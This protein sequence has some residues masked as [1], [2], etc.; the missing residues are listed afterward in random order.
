MFARTIALVFI[1]SASAQKCTEAESKL[2]IDQYDFTKNM[3]TCAMKGMGSSK[4]ASNCLV[5][6]YS[7]ALS[8][9]CATCFGETIACGAKS[10]GQPCS[11]DPSC[12]ECKEC[13]YSSGCDGAMKACTGI[14]TGP[15]S[16][17]PKTA[18]DGTTATT[19]SA[20]SIGLLSVSSVTASI[21]VLA[22]IF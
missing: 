3:M 2:W 13:A 17:K 19:K 16:P 5:D 22:I 12:A 1:A 20:T 18:A 4:V 11:K 8:L 9:D 10:C 15:M 21:L 7:G 6:K 14:E